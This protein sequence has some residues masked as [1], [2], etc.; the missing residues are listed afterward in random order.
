VFPGR[1]LKITRRCHER[2]LFFAPNAAAAKNNLNGFIGYCLAHSANETHV[3]IHACVVLSDHL[4]MD[5][6]DPYGN[7]SQFKQRFH[8]M[9][10]RGIN[11]LRGRCD[12]VWSGDGPRDTW[13]PSEEKTLGDL[14]YTLTNPVKHGLVKRGDRWPGFTTY[15]WRFGES[16]VFK[17]PKWFFDPDGDMPEQIELTLERPPVCPELDDDELFDTMMDAVRTRESQLQAK[18]RREQRR[19]V[20]VAKLRRQR[21]DAQATTFE[22]RFRRAPSY[23]TSDPSLARAEQRRDRAW[24]SE[25]AA[26]RALLLAGGDPV[27]PH[28]TDWMRRFAGVTVGRAPP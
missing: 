24:R 21:W 22:Q 18:R 25:Y 2:R 5:V 12:T 7:I 20:G 26:A 23:G 1:T 3:Q 15:G 19:F 11:V 8:S 28:G 10:A 6:T 9:L 14:V 17:R 13:R 4:H 16:R 27:F